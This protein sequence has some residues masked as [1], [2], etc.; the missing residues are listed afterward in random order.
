MF[1]VALNV[2]KIQAK[3]WLRWCDVRYFFYL[4][5]WV[6]RQSLRW[7]LNENHEFSWYQFAISPSCILNC[8]VAF[9]HFFKDLLWKIFT[10]SIN[11]L[12]D[13][14]DESVVWSS[15]SLFLFSL[16]VSLFS[17]RSANLNKFDK[18]PFILLDI[19]ITAQKLTG[20]CGK[21]QRFHTIFSMQYKLHEC[22][23]NYIHFNNCEISIKKF[24]LK[25]I[26]ICLNLL[27]I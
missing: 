10:L 15:L 6:D 25:N 7:L 8:I 20:S 3:K 2:E 18:F 22:N 24:I 9:K 23:K 26:I 4:W 11:R 13:M 21:L 5:G 16:Y 17:L 12:K 19:S 27:K 14:E 1:D